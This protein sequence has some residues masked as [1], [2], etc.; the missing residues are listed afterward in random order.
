MTSTLKATFLLAIISL[1]ASVAQAQSAGMTHI[2]P[3]VVDGV[4]SDGTVFTS[5]FLISGIGGSSTCQI[6]LF[7]MGLER[8]SARSSILVEGSFFETVTTRG[9][10]VM[11]TG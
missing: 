6:S 9:E 7:G 5:R 11:E 10:D 3:Q 4:G 8:L 2:F 1:T